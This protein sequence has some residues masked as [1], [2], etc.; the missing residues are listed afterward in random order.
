MPQTGNATRTTTPV[1]AL[2]LAVITGLVGIAGGVAGISVWLALQAIQF[3]AFGYP[4]GGHREAADAPS[5]STASSRSPRPACSRASRG[6]R[7]GG[8]RSPWCR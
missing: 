6:G 8:G 5:G 3:V 4:F 7:S 2:K 1:W